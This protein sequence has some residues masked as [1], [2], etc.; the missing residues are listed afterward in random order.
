LKV[1]VA[2]PTLAAGEAIAQ[3]RKNGGPFRSLFDVCERCDPSV[4]NRTAIESLVK[5]GAFDQLHANRASLWQSLDL[6]TLGVFTTLAGLA[7][8]IF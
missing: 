7:F 5:A 8:K 2:V 1:T 4:L 3:A 6:L